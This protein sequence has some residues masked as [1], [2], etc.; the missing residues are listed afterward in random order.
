M[1]LDPQT[2][3]K[4]LRTFRAATVVSRPF[5]T[6]VAAQRKSYAAIF[7]I[8]PVFLWPNAGPIGLVDR[9]VISLA[10]SIAP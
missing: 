1:C 4:T 10:W 2:R 5:A 9:T 3:D 6:P 7:W 8:W